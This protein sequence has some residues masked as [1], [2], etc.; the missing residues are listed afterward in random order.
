M[1]E[2]QLGLVTMRHWVPGFTRVTPSSR[3]KQTE[4]GEETAVGKLVTGKGSKKGNLTVVLD[5]SWGWGGAGIMGTQ[6]VRQS[7]PMAFTSRETRGHRL[8]ELG[9]AVGREGVITDKESGSQMWEPPILASL[10][11]G[12]GSGTRSLSS[13]LWLSHQVSTL[14]GVGC[15]GGRGAEPWSLLGSSL[16]SSKGQGSCREWRLSPLPSPLSSRKKNWS[17]LFGARTNAIS[18]SP[19]T[20]V[21]QAIYSDPC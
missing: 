9:A 16:T 18:R 10:C 2:E 21:I 6:C 20:V 19:A 12:K 14:K 3:A 1:C 4:H 7:W 11:S 15:V 17:S 5:L 8:P 13:L